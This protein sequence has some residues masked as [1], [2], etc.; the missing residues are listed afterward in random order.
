MSTLTAIT[1]KGT[2]CDSSMRTEILRK[3]AVVNGQ[4]AKGENPN[5]KPLIREQ[6][7]AKGYTNGVVQYRFTKGLNSITRF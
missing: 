1:N 2:A 5:E 4:I 7:L 3:R 6:H